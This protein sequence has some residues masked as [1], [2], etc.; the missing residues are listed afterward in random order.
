MVSNIIASLSQLPTP[1]PPRRERVGCTR[2]CRVEMLSVESKP[3]VLVP[4]AFPAA[5]PDTGAWAGAGEAGCWLLP[6]RDLLAAALPLRAPT[7]SGRDE[8]GEGVLG[9]DGREGRVRRR[10]LGL[11]VCGAAIPLALEH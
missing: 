11:L 3:G 8:G 4:A 7:M 10:R 6:A 2:R 5:D 9:G 1:G